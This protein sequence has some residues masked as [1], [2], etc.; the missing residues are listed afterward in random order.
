MYFMSVKAVHL[1]CSYST[2]FL[3]L[4]VI[5]SP[6]FPFSIRVWDYPSKQCTDSGIFGSVAT[7]PMLAAI[8]LFLLLR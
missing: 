1:K 8:S 4:F 5:R 7:L 2:M 3:V 6:S